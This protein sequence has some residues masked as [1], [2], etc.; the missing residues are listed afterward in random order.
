MR[1]DSAPVELVAAVLG[2]GF[3]SMIPCIGPVG[4]ARLMLCS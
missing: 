1:G 4:S 2:L 3:V